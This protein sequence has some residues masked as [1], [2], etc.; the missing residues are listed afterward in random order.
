MAKQTTPEPLQTD[1]VGTPETKLESVEAKASDAKAT[2]KPTTYT[3]VYKGDRRWESGGLQIGGLSFVTDREQVLT[4]EQHDALQQ[5][6]EGNKD[7]T[8][9]IKPMEE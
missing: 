9:R 5:A 8:F 4:A 2:P 3:V 7:Y 6:L 1:A